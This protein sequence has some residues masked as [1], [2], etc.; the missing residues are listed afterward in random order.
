MNCVN[1]DTMKRPSSWSTQFGLGLLRLAQLASNGLR[2]GMRRITYAAVVGSCLTLAS[3]IAMS[4]A[5]AQTPVPDWYR[6]VSVSSPLGCTSPVFSSAKQG[7]GLGETEE[8]YAKML[9][10]VRPA[11]P[12]IIST[13]SEW[14]RRINGEIH[15]DS[16]SVDVNIFN[17]NDTARLV[18]KHTYSKME[19]GQHQD[20]SFTESAVIQGRLFS[21][22]SKVNVTIKW[23]PYVCVT[24]NDRP[25][26]NMYVMPR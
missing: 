4:S 1:R 17:S 9:C 24:L 13:P 12:A 6:G 3:V 5:Q 21:G 11:E 16:G 15:V 25:V 2:W 14:L 10:D 8:W 19:S 26:C 20:F 23:S 22:L 7:S 18:P